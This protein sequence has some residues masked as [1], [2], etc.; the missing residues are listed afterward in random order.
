[1]RPEDKSAIKYIAAS[2]N[3]TRAGAEHVWG[4]Y[5]NDM[6]AMVRRDAKAWVKNGSP[7]PVPRDLVSEQNPV[8]ASPL[9]QPAKQRPMKTAA[10]PR[11]T[12]TSGTLETMPPIQRAALAAFAPLPKKKLYSFYI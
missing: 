9:K 10:K 1:M 4:G 3:L 5:S 7:K 11:T 6:R 8:K 12:A 2:L